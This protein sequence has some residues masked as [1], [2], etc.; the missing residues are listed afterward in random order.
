MIDAL[1]ARFLPRF[2]ALAR[3]RLERAREA[4]ARKDFDAAH[5]TARELHA[6]AGE[7]GLLGLATVVPLARAGEDF[8][9]AAAASKSD[10]DGESLASALEALAAA[11]EALAPPASADLAQPARRP[12]A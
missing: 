3:T 9:R 7:A 10:R 12:D 1:Q 11:V 8:A 4:A 5:E 6:I 2:T